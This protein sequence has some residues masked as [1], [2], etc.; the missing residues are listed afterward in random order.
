MYLIFNELSVEAAAVYDE[1]KKT[2]GITE[3]QIANA[4]QTSLNLVGDRIY[5]S[6]IIVEEKSELVDWTTKDAW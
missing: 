6:G 5:L 4:L 1:L 3:R 2:E